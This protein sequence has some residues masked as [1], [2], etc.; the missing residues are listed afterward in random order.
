M[1]P[2]TASAKRGQ[3]RVCTWAPAMG[4]VQRQ[5]PD[6][7]WAQLW[8]SLP[9]PTL[10]FAPQRSPAPWHQSWPGIPHL[11]CQGQTHKSR[12]LR[13]LKKLKIELPY[14]I[15]IPFLGI[16][17]EKTIIQKD[18]CTPMFITALFTIAKTWKQPKYPSTGEW[19]KMWYIHTMEY[20]SAIK[21]N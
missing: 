21:K 3:G 6:K 8:G 12:H 13:F 16:C 19:I 11:H 5:K 20:Y 4:G 18:T 14:G 2:R 17:P 15:A 7:L 1:S 9:A 10:A